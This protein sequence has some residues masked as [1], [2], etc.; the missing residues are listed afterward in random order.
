MPLCAF[1]GEGD[2][3]F[4]T[5]FAEDLEWRLFSYPLGGDRIR[6]DSSCDRYRWIIPAPEEVDQ[7]K[8][9]MGSELL[10]QKRHT[11]DSIGPEIAVILPGAA[12]GNE[13]PAVPVV[14]QSQRL[15]IAAR[16]FGC[17][18]VPISDA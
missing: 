7:G 1:D 16:G 9:L 8:T 4:V 3:L 10:R 6:S 2:T 14:G 11:L 17:A 13:M 15:D 12:P 18:R 5:F